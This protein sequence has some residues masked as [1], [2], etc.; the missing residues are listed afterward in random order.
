V[1]WGILAALVIGGI[2][3]SILMRRAAALADLAEHDLDAAAVPA[4]GRRTSASWS[5][6]YTAALRRFTMAG[7]VMAVIVVVTVFI[8]AMHLG[9]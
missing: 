9:A 5:P 8:M 1:G 6:E 7:N 3:G 4:G 2:E